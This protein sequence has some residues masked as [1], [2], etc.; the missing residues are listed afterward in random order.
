MMKVAFGCDHGGF[1]LKKDILAYLKKSGIDVIDFGTDSE[2]GVDYPDYARPVCQSV[3]DGEA[4]FGVLVCGAGVGISISANKMRGIRCALVGDT[5]T[6]RMTREHNDANV[7]A[8][9]GR[10]TGPGP[11]VDIIDIFLHTKFS[12]DERHQRRIDKIMALEE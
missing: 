11:A 4:D 5:Y 3:L 9:G 12:G 6:A 8:L 1:I 10:V 2:A 7:V